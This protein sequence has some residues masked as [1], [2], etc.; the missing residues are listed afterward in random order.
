MKRKLSIKDYYPI[1]RVG[2]EIYIDITNEKVTKITDDKIYT[3]AC[4][5]NWNEDLK[6]TLLSQAKP[7]W[8]NL[9]AGDVIIDPKSTEEYVQSSIISAVL[10]K[11][12][13][14]D[15]D[16]EIVFTDR[17][18]DDG[19]TIKDTRE[20]KE[21]EVSE[22]KTLKALEDSIK[23]NQKVYKQWCEDIKRLIEK[24]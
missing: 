4:R 21:E 7:D 6:L 15:G 5:Y 17:L 11:D 24:I 23:L 8:D 19:Y 14:V 20:D 9:R 3:D 12:V 22:E 1:A 18:R 2:D 10:N 16:G 13:I